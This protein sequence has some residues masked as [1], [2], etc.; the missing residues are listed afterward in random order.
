MNKIEAEWMNNSTEVKASQTSKQ[1]PVTWMYREGQVTRAAN[2][3]TTKHSCQAIASGK[4]SIHSVQGRWF[5][6]PNSVAE[7]PREG[8]RVAVGT[9]FMAIQSPCENVVVGNIGSK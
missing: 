5:T 8:V 9:R 7:P 1:K 6:S 4:E 3:V 2:A